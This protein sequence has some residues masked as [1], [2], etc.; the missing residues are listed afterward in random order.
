MSDSKPVHSPI[1]GVFYRRP[2][3]DSPAFVE[4]GGSVDADTVIGLIEVMK[5]F[6]EIKAG[7]NGRIVSFAVEDEGVVNAGDVV[8]EIQ[9]T[10]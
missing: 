6:H 8:A 5:Q 3:P 9:S 2:D 1:P 10:E 4:E 7:T